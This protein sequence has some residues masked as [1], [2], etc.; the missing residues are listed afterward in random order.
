MNIFRE[1]LLAKLC[2]SS[3]CNGQLD[4][5]NEQFVGRDRLKGAKRDYSLLPQL[6]SNLSSEATTEES[7]GEDVNEQKDRR[8]ESLSS[9][10]EACGDETCT[11]YSLPT[12]AEEFL[13]NINEDLKE[14]SDECKDQRQALLPAINCDKS[15]SWKRDAAKPSGNDKL[16]R[17]PVNIKRTSTGSIDL[18]SRARKY[19]DSSPVCF[20]CQL[21]GVGDVHP[22]CPISKL[23]K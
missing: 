14:Y 16:L 10:S 4:E 11:G 17:L 13:L 21:D 19:L 5:N 8:C 23:D 9:G 1:K 18:V 20:S 12:L 6:P 15:N 2:I 7:F 3:E 22:A